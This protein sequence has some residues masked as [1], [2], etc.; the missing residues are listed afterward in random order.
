M[1][2]SYMSA[3]ANASLNR[4]PRVAQ[5]KIKEIASNDSYSVWTQVAWGDL[6]STLC[7]DAG[8]S[9]FAIESRDGRLSIQRNGNRPA[10]HYRTSRRLDG[11]RQDRERYRVHGVPYR[12]TGDHRGRQRGECRGNPECRRLD[13]RS[14]DRAPGYAPLAAIRRI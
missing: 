12:P 7:P 5:P 13:Y 3:L 8:V 14:P 10:G 6:A 9:S 4:E 1:P 2:C 11:R